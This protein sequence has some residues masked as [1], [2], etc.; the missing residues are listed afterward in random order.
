MKRGFCLLF[1]AYL[2]LTGC[3]TNFC[4]NPTVFPI[5]VG[6][7]ADSQITS[8]NG[9]SDFHYRSKFA[10]TLVDVSIRPPALE[11]FLAE[12][13]LQVGLNK[14]T[15]DS[16][17]DKKGV[18]VILYLGDAANSGGTDEIDKVLTILARHR[19]QTGVPIYIIIGNH[20][21]LGAGNIITPGIRF[22]LLNQIGRPDNPALTKYEVLKR[23][24]DF[25]H[26]NN[27]LPGNRFKYTDNK[28]ALEQNKNLEHDTGLYLSG[29]LMY[30]EEGKDL[31]DI[32]LLDTSDY[33]DAPDWSGVAKVG[34]YGAIG[35]VSFKDKPGF[36][37]QMSYFKEF[38]RSSSP[39][40]QLLASHYPKDHL[41][42]ITLAKP[43]QVPLD[44]TN[45]IWSVTENAISLP[46]FSKTFNQNLEPVL[47]S[48]KR[49]YWL[50]GH[51]HT[52]TMIKPELF[53]V[54]GLTGAYF[55]SLNVG[56]T[57]DYRAHV[58]VIERYKRNRNDRNDRM[59]D[60][61][62]Y[63][64]IPIFEGCDTLLSSI[65]NAIA[66][67]GRSHA[68]DPNFK[69]FIPTFEEWRKENKKGGIEN[70][71]SSLF[72]LL[73]KSSATAEMDTYWTD[74]GAIVLGLNRAYLKDN[75]KDQQTE[76]SAANL[77]AF[78]ADFVNRTGSN[79]E[80]VLSF[81]GLLS[82]AY[83][84]GLLPGKCDLSP[85]C[86]KTLCED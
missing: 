59:D 44:L 69:I 79:R 81:L 80:E 37:S 33:K 74:V 47:L 35:S 46:T 22:A 86:L 63:R 8:Q 15:L 13:M 55:T 27:Q 53:I 31:V 16:H 50:S 41:D 23:F 24:S 45:F 7:L 65:P 2:L 5:K 40:F 36:V 28:D 26:E 64:E 34:L 75:W 25:N 68:D 39:Q 43:G 78:A 17:G 1:L 56:S 3:E 42:R 6:L 12:E 77:R 71:G 62:G 83:E 49:N 52:S 38:A 54:G 82:G 84:S 18:D 51:T 4:R 11:C 66:E 32:F 9:F 60:F 76:T 67:Y 48:G 57:T 85:V 72:G 30:R 14:L 10:D 21:Y 19:K 58:T 70:I 73:G 61:V 20:D 29:V